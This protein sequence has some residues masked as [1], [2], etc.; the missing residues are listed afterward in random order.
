[1]FQSQLMRRLN[2]RNFLWKQSSD[3][4]FNFW[5]IFGME[6]LSIPF[7]LFLPFSTLFALFLAFFRY[8]LSLH[9]LTSFFSSSVDQIW[10][11]LI[12][13]VNFTFLLKK[14]PRIKCAEFKARYLF[15]SLDCS[16]AISINTNVCFVCLFVCRH[17]VCYTWLCWII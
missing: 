4:I 13:S 9:T 11:I 3:G 12:Y 8:I 6:S 5:I 15:Y 17:F 16:F 10:K 1:M 2:S 7:H 14:F